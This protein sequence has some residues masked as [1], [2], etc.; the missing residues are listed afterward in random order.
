[1]AAKAATQA[2]SLSVSAVAT[3]NWR[4]WVAA[5]AAMTDLMG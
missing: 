2:W 4:D 5:F 3:P 1:M